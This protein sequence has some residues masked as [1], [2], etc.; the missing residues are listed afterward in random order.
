MGRAHTSNKFHIAIVFK[1]QDAREE[2]K[3]LFENIRHKTGDN[4]TEITV[5][6]LKHYLKYLKE[7]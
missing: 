3:S 1:G 7:G 6:A 4:F 2:C 5:E